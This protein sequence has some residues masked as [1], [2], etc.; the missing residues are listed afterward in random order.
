[1]NENNKHSKMRLSERLP[2]HS[3][4]PETWNRL[5]G[6]LDALDA[7][8]VY[9]EKLQELPVHSPDQG[10]WANINQRLNRAAYF[11]TGVRIALSAAAGLLLFFT[12]SRISDYYSESPS[13]SQ[14]ASYDQSKTPLK[15]TTQT[16]P[17]IALAVESSKTDAIPAVKNTINKNAGIKESRQSSNLKT[18]EHSTSI[19]ADNNS[20]AYST[21]I[22]DLFKGE[23]SSVIA[24]SD[25]DAVSNMQ[26]TLSKENTTQRFTKFTSF[27]ESVLSL[28]KSMNTQ[29][30][31]NGTDVQKGKITQPLIPPVTYNAPKN[32]ETVAKANN[33]ALAMGYFPENIDNGTDNSVFYNVDLTASYNKERVRFNTSVGMAYNEEQFEVNMSYDIKSPVTA[34]GPGGRIDTVAYNSA[35]LQSDYV[36]SEK[37]QYFTYNLGFG[38]RLFSLGKFSTWINAGAGFGLKL[39]N[40]DLVTATENSIKNQYSAQ[41]TQV[42]TDRPVYNDVNVNLVTGI[43]F[44]YRF[45][46]KLSF[47]FSPTSRWYFK[48]VLSKNNQPTDEL[49]LG[50]KTGIKFDF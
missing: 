48:P 46:N 28:N 12:V 33:F 44:N 43:D 34:F 37:H 41:I 36:G 45:L 27:R 10:L 49:T 6:K 19:Q 35:S 40:P 39:N 42:S 24:L 38:R 32:P 20:V 11:K 16:N 30:G 26:T 25:S 15:A 31:L 21:G 29:F 7:E 9:Q 8:A 2:V 50:F 22:R 13:A 14:V 5:S 18:Y 47:T 4:D 23:T 1:M 3:A 17:A